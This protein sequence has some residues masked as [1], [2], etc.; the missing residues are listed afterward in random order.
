MNAVHTTS[1]QIFGAP[2]N[3]ASK[4]SVKPDPE[5]KM[6][7][8]PANTGGA[9]MIEGAM[10]YVY[11]GG[12][13]GAGAQQKKQHAL[14]TF[15]SR[16]LSAP[17]SSKGVLPGYRE[18]PTVEGTRK[19]AIEARKLKQR[20]E[21]EMLLMIERD[22]GHTLG[23]QYL[24]ARSAPPREKL[25]GKA[26]KPDKLDKLKRKRHQ[27][28]VDDLGDSSA[29]EEEAKRQRAG[30]SA[31]TIRRIGFDPRLAAQVTMEGQGAKSSSLTKEDKK[32]QAEHDQLVKSL[33]RE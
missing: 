33:L 3:K 19:D 15:G 4:S 6:G 32:L 21:E 2:S 9:R 10:T 20:R 12:P 27:E 26:D 13:S 5:R 18:G 22:G 11:K 29:E 8:L 16:E 23:G 24:Q 7:L 30:F 17:R 14:T 28:N 31:S 1:G 25:L